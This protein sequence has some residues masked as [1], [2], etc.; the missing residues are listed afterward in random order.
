[1][2]LGVNTG[3]DIPNEVKL[4]VNT[5]QDIPSEVKL[6]VNTGHESTLARIFPV[7]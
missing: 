3:Q 2:K 7:K 5:G 6:G 4:G 1:M